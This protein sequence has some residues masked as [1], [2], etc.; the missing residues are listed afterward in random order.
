MNEPASAERAQKA[1]KDSH[2]TDSGGQPTGTS[3]KTAQR[4][5]SDHQG[6]DVADE[7]PEPLPGYE[8]L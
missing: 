6:S 3:G 8:H 4:E 7:R 1:V 5:A 2:D